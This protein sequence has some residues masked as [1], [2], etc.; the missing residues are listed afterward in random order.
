MRTTDPALLPILTDADPRLRER[1]APVGAIG[2]EV[3]A[4]VAAL[5]ACLHAY[6]AAHGFGRGIAAP[7]LGI[8]RRIVVLDLGAGP[9]ALIDPE[10]IWRDPETRAVWDDCFSLPGRLVRVRR[11]RSVSLR[12]R[13]AAGRER[14]WEKLPFDLAELVQHELDHLDGVL[15]SDRAEGSD[16]IRPADARASL[17]DAVRPVHRLSLASIA[18]AADAIDAAFANSPQYDNEALSDALGCRL[19]LKFE[20][21][22]P[23]RCFKGRGADWYLR[24]RL[25]RG[26]Q[27][28]LVCASAGNFGQALAYACRARGVALTVFAAGTANA[29]KVARM[30]ALGADVRLHGADFDAAK[31]AARVHASQSNAQFVEDGREVEIS[32]GAGTIAVELLRE[33]PAPDALLVPLGNG[34]LL[35]GIARWTRARSPATRIVGVVARGAPAMRDSWRSGRAVCG[36]RVDTIADGIAVRVPV[37]EALSDLHGLVDDIVAVDDADLIAAMRLVHRHA[38]VVAEPAGVAGI[39]ALLAQCE[40]YA[41]QRVA[42][43][44]CGGNLTPE[45]IHDW[46]LVD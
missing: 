33:D 15:M 37:D 16:A 22:N 26:E 28:A 6:R 11:H 29:L 5:A 40:A 38:G 19:L 44:L 20:L 30:R 31:A 1:A 23:I 36:E 34:A 46:L 12:Y 25:A 45:Q 14:R 39:A 35:N 42:S 24:R 21:F 2:A 32:E 4:V 41:G 17:V 43:V 13:D 27:G 7:Q 10:I 3:H 8:A 9:I 18:A